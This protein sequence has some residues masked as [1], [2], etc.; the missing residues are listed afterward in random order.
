MQVSCWYDYTCQYSWRAQR[1]LTRVQE[2]GGDL[3]VQW[4]TFSLKGANRDPAA[5]S[6][7]DDPQISS[8]SVLALALAHA[9]READ[10]DQ[11]HGAVFA[12]MHADGRHLDE[13]QL[14]A[15]AADAGVDLSAFEENRRRWLTAVA[16]EHRDAVVRHAVFGT[17]TLVLGGGATVFVKL[18]EV[19]PV[20]DDVALWQALCVLTTCHPE[21]LEIKRPT[22][23]P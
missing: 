9:A 21:I 22:P 15:I 2:G 11:Y 18:A 5:P 12:A 14:L 10:F 7:F 8:L 20:H 1:W 17:P 13:G 3:S 23:Q 19:P 16:A 6:P 4:R